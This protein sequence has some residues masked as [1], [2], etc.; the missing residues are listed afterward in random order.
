M[1]YVTLI[2]AVLCV[3][4]LLQGGTRNAFLKV[5]LPVLLVFPT[6]FYLQITHLPDLNFIDVTLIPLA[7]WMF[8]VDLPHW[9]YTRMDLVVVLFIF[10]CGY[11]EF[12]IYHGWRTMAL[13]V[14]EGLI[15]YMAGKVV[16]Q[17]PGTRIEATKRF[18]VLVTIASFLGMYEYF[19]KTN[20]YKEFW[21]RFY[22]GQWGGATTQIR[23]GFG[24]MSGPYVQ[25]EA[26]GIVIMTALLLGLWVLRWRAQRG[27][28]PDPESRP[29]KY[30]K[31]V[32]FTL[33]LALVMTEA[34]GPWIGAVI[35][36]G[37]ASIGLAKNPRRRSI[38]FVAVLLL[39]GVPAYQF[40]KD[41]IS[42][43]RTSYGSERET[44][45]YRAALI[46]NYVPLA[47]SGGPWG[48]GRELP[49]VQGQGSIDNEYLFVW[50][51]QGYIG[52]V[53][54]LLLMSGGTLIF[55]NFGIKGESRRDRELGFALLGILLGLA[56]TLTTVW[57]GAQSFE[58]FFL[59]LGLSQVI[60]PE[61]VAQLA[62]AANNSIPELHATPV[63]RVYT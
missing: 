47:Q 28:V 61:N 11:S 2:P 37:V 44:A 25:S 48:F 20:P 49:I 39:V 22:P 53:T 29:L 57:L 41:Y 13:A 14:I 38:V 9:R 43:R 45:Q 19:Y 50:L 17:D 3:Y 15:P 40:G 24:R 46:D 8:V 30:V 21:A 27:G 26:A 23:W 55:F 51:V 12:A 59:L 7:L 6:N 63:L 58:V 60:K 35:A 16:L 31:L 1:P 32:V 18:V 33:V 42:G 10:S 52:L 56:F 34:R 4:A 54:F 36:L 62:R 5:V